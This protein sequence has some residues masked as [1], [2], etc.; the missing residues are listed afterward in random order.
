MPVANHLQQINVNILG[1][2]VALV[3]RVMRESRKN[4]K[5]IASTDI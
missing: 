2:F 3:L 4:L 1:V 5:K